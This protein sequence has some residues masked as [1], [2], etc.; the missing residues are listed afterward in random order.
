MKRRHLFVFIAAL[1]VLGDYLGGGHAITFVGG[2]VFGVAVA[3]LR[4]SQ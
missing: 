3:G 1:A 2:A 4:W